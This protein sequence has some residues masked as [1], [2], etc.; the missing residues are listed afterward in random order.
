[1]ECFDNPPDRKHSNSIK[2]D[3]NQKKFGRED[4]IPLWIA[5][6][7][8]AAPEVITE[9]INQR[10]QHPIFGYTYRTESFTASVAGWLA[11]RFEW[12]VSKE[13]LLFY[14]PGTVSAINALVN[15]FSDKG[16]EII[17]HTPAYPPLMNI[18]R[19][20][21]RILIENP[22][23][24]VDGEFRI[25]FEL[26]ERSITEK[27]RILLFC[28]PHNPTG[29]V[30]RLEE[31]MKLAELCQRNNLLV[32]SDEVHADLV[33][34]RR[35][36]HHFNRIPQESRGKSIT[37]ISTCKSFNI[38]A[39]SQSTLISDDRKISQKIR[40]WINT[41]QLNLDNIFSA[42]ATEAAY[43]G[44]E[45]W[46]DELLLYLADNRRTLCDWFKQNL[47]QVKV[48]QAQG[49]YLAWLDFRALN[50]S[51]QELENILINKA[52]VGLYDGR[53]FGPNGDG[54]FRFNFACSRTT[55]KQALS[56]ISDAFAKEDA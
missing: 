39:M 18:V 28:S 50:Y 31:L 49:T 15:L 24:E 41:S 48:C 23:K 6:M 35:R 43:T 7:D 45:Q 11:Q 2:W 21:Q 42:V 20:N 5:D 8:F 47:P 53:Y 9:A 30:W 56:R 16:D 17:V 52:G 36:H 54:F 34:E 4:V 13:S 44:G 32:I 46:L 25:D 33:F 14:P 38:A 27:T 1:M 51:H 22:L 37:L 3:C 40:H 19:Q 55:L 10:L 26:F 12:E 29:R